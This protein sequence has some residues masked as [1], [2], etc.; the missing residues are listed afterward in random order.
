MIYLLVAF[1]KNVIAWRCQNDPLLG[2][3]R[4]FPHAMQLSGISSMATRMLLGELAALYTAQ[5]GVQLRIESVGG[6]DAAKRVSA[7][8]AFDV[9]LLA[10]DAI[11]KLIASGHV[12]AASKTDWVASGV[13]ACVRC[14]TA[15]PDFSS[16]EA[17]KAAVLAAKTV[18]YSTGPS[19]V[20]LAK[21]FEH[22]GIAEQIA[23]RIVTAPPGVPV[24]S[25]VASGDVELGFQQLSELLNVSGVDLIP[26]LP[27]DIQINTVFSS[28]VAVSSRQVAAAQAFLDFLNT[29]QT[30]ALKMKNG[31]TPLI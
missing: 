23:S 13:A 20:Q 24:A 10:S 30:T 19:G 29:A 14:G 8:E 18:A 5:S 4:I 15:K 27:A 25:L 2:F 21:Q 12:L 17:V 22:W 31:M 26:A 1:D 7:G 28:A 9:V 16:G 6:V 11:D 3:F